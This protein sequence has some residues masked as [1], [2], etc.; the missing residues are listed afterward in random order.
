[1][2]S[3]RGN[4]SLRNVQFLRNEPT[5]LLLPRSEVNL[6]IGKKLIYW[7]IFGFKDE[8]N[9]LRWYFHIRWASFFWFCPQVTVF[10]DFLYHISLVPFLNSTSADL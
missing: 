8:A 4:L 9:E 5:V 3:G 2:P 10:E 7:N 1:M 6:E